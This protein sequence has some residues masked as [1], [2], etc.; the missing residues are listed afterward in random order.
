MSSCWR[1]SADRLGLIG[2]IWPS[3]F[4]EPPPI[5]SE[6]RHFFAQGAPRNIEPLQDGADLAAGFHQTPLDERALE[7]F[8][9]LREREASPFRRRLARREGFGQTERV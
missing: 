3:G 5:E 2:G 1:F 4:D 7:G 8:D 9:L 6:P